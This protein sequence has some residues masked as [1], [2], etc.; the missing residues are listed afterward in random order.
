MPRDKDSSWKLLSDPL[1]V[2]ATLL[3]LIPMRFL[4]NCRVNRKE[5]EVVRSLLPL[6]EITR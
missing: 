1:V 2:I 4:S 6:K 3:V 5:R